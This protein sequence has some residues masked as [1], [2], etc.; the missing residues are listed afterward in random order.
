[1]AV[2][3]SHR[4]IRRRLMGRYDVVMK[5]VAPATR[6]GSG[7]L[8]ISGAFAAI[9]LVGAGILTLPWASEDGDWTHPWDALFT[10]VSAICTTGLVVVDTQ[11]HWSFF[12]ELVILVLFQVG[13]LGYMV[14]TAVVLWALG[15]RLGLRD[16]EMLR[17]YYGAPD[18]SETLRFARTIGLYALIMEAAGAAVLLI[19]FRLDGVP[20]S[21]SLWWGIFHSVSAFNLAGFNITGADMQPYADHAPILLPIAFLAIAGSI[22]GV[23]VVVVARRRSLRRLPLDSKLILGTTA[24]MLSA[25]TL[26]LL[27]WEWN[28]PGTF[29]AHNA[30]YRPMLAFFRAAMWT[31]GFSSVDTGALGHESKLFLWGLMFVGGA[32]GSASGGIKVG[33]F[34]LLFFAMVATLR[35]R[36]DVEALGRR[37]PIMV[38]RQALTISLIFV[39]VVFV[40]STSLVAVSP[41]QDALD[42]VFEEISALATVGWS[43]GHTAEF[44]HAGRAILILGMLIGR[45]APLLLIL[46]MTRPRRRSTTR[47]PEDS[48]RLG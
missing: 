20:W 26:L 28:N 25:A 10:S 6:I 34:A 12:G 40:L 44:N 29:G 38:I 16:Q 30:V 18:A 17:L 15:R 5:P 36:E 2:T 47:L 8:P 39:G 21:E 46:G 24:V 9:I 45:F 23:P 43:A 13:G 14:G 7:I 11:A 35:G 22:G 27:F 41:D 42:T 1:M 19:G 3:V 4:P 31:T 37:V 32:P 48:I 33:T